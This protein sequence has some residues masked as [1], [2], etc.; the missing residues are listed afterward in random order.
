MDQPFSKD[1]SREKNGSNLFEVAEDIDIPIFNLKTPYEMEPKFNKNLR[2][3]AGSNK[4]IDKLN[5]DKLNT[6]RRR[7]QDRAPVSRDETF[8]IKPESMQT[9][10]F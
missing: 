3:P 4:G 2:K 9:D 6:T 1:Y 8:K 10:K 7:R 5:F